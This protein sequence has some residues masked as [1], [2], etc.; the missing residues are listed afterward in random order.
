ML[1]HIDRLPAEATRLLRLFLAGSSHTLSNLVMDL[2]YAAQEG[3][4]TDMEMVL[5]LL[6]A[7]SVQ[8]AD[9]P[10]LMDEQPLSLYR[11]PLDLAAMLRAVEGSMRARFERVPCALRILSDPAWIDGDETRLYRVIWLCVENANLY[12]TYI[13]DDGE[14][15]LHLEVGA[16]VSVLIDDNGPGVPALYLAQ[17]GTPSLRLYDEIPGS[18]WSLFYARCVLEAH[19][20]ALAFEESPLGGLR[21]RITL[22]HAVASTA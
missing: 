14:V 17:L 9:L 7:Y 6:R 16:C 2:D 10:L 5:R 8:L 18:G 4:P 15:Q 13:R 12:T 21:V 22:P 19:G 1:F 20:G 11:R 3:K